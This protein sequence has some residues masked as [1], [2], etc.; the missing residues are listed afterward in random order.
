MGKVG[1]AELYWFGV[2]LSSML[3]ALKI[4][5]L[6]L[7]KGKYFKPFKTGKDDLQEGCTNLWH[8]VARATKL[9]FFY[10]GA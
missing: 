5:W 9:I 8:K 4:I 6:T 1:L 2:K 7:I 10:V 3:S